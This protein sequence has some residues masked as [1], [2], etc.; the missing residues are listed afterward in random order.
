MFPEESD[1]SKFLES[2][3]R[4]ASG[5]PRG[6]IS[7]DLADLVHLLDKKVNHLCFKYFKGSNNEV[8]ATSPIVAV[9]KVSEPGQVSLSYVARN[10]KISAYYIFTLLHKLVKVRNS[11][12]F[13]F[14]R[15]SHAF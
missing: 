15:I 1:N 10:H 11:F 4:G 14:T 5:G 13:L 7:W 9:K 8:L 6:Q 12:E 3:V 2:K